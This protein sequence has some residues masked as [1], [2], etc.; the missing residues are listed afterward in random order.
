MKDEH[1]KRTAELDGL[2]SAGARGAAA[3]PAGKPSPFSSMKDENDNATIDFVS[4]EERARQEKH[5]RLP[6]QS[7]YRPPQGAKPVDEGAPLGWGDS[8]VP[9]ASV[10]RDWGISARRVRVM[11]A[12]G[13]LAGRQ[14]DNGYWEVLYPYRYMFGTRGPAIK[15]QRELPP[16]TRKRAPKTE[17]E[18]SGW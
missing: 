10:A 16:P 4:Q 14:L 9:V 3:R 15:R 13:R 2:A 12:E 7:I 1:D 5:K 11:L 6:R 17:E 18:F 8:F